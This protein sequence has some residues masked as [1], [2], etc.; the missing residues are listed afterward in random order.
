MTT[1][2]GHVRSGTGTTRMPGMRHVPRI[3]L[4]IDVLAVTAAGVLAVAGR[5]RLP[6]FTPTEGIQETLGLAGPLMV[7]GWIV[8][9]ALVGGYRTTTFG[10]GLAEYKQ[11]ASASFLAAGL[12]GV[13]CYLAKFDL[14]RGFFLLAFGLGVPVLLLG[15]WGLRHALHAAH[16]RGRLLTRVLVAG[17]AR[18]VDEVAAVL[19]RESWLGYRVT[20]ALTPEAGAE[21]ATGVPIL[22][23]ADEVAALALAHGADLVVFGGGSLSSGAQ[24]RE[25]VWELEQHGIDVVVAPSLSDV[26][27][28]RLTMRPVGGLPLIHVAHSNWAAASHLGKRTFDAIGSA[29]LIAAL[30]P[31]FVV[32][33]TQI[34]LHDRGPIIYRQERIA[35]DGRPF[36]CFKFRTMVPYAEAQATELQQAA[37]QSALLFKLKDDPRVT[38]PGRW[39]RR[40]SVD[41]LPQLFNVLRGEMS[42]VGPRPQVQSEVDLYRGGMNRRLLVRPGLT[43]LWQVSGR[44]DLTPEEAIRLDLFYVDNWSMLQDLAILAR[45]VRAVLSSRGAY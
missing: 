39:L 15:R 36:A 44:N 1:L 12:T 19:R 29:L 35:R 37:N 13:G 24:M 20:G 41:E 45:T 18:H 9:L 7:A 34:W 10:S 6:V 30:S 22:G 2:V 14:S 40:F 38:Q 25:K 26:A 21:S 11:I 3:A 43:G 5:E 27:G 23:Q 31:L 8:A 42:L 17:D 4:F 28:D 16:R 32:A 33:A